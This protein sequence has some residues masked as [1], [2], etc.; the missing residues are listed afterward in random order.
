MKIGSYT[1]P[2]FLPE[3][4]ENMKSF[5]PWDGPF[6]FQLAYCRVWLHFPMGG[7]V[8]R[9]DFDWPAA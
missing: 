4:G 2:S 3:K 7:P 8:K 1:V 6:N 5:G 9:L